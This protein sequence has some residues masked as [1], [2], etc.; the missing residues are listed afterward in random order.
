MSVYEME[1]HLYT[2][3]FLGVEDLNTEEGGNLCLR[4]RMQEEQRRV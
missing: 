2:T 3:V 1:V 4:L